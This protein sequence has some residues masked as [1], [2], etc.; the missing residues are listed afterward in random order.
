MLFL[1]NLIT[2]KRQSKV[3]QLLI[4]KNKLN[5]IQNTPIYVWFILARLMFVF[6]NPQKKQTYHIVTLFIIPILLI[7]L[8]HKIFYDTPT[9]II[10]YLSGLIIG[11]IFGFYV[12]KKME[13]KILKKTQSIE[14]SENYQTLTIILAYFCIRYLFGMLHATNPEVAM[15]YAPYETCIIALFSGFILGKTLALTHKY[16]THK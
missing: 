14:I 15:T 16:L 8:K 5:L 6:F 13:V 10:T 1:F 11:T 9:M 3:F 2:L 12:G 7:A 4:V